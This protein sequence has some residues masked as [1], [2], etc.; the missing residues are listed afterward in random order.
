M[1]RLS[2]TLRT[3][4]DEI[5]RQIHL[6]EKYREELQTQLEQ[7]DEDLALVDDAVRIRKENENLSRHI[8]QSSLDKE[9]LE[10]RKWLTGP[11]PDTPSPEVT[12]EK[13]G[14]WK[15]LPDGSKKRVL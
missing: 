2:E 4:R 12:E 11:S 7:V 13:F 15:Y 3:R 5:L 9:V 10:P 6:N 8:L 14:N 1:S